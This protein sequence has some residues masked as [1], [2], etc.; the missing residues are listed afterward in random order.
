M[1][2]KIERKAPSIER[3]NS[4]FQRK[5]VKINRENIFDIRE[6]LEAEGINPVDEIGEMPTLEAEQGA[7]VNAVVSDIRK[8]RAEYAEL[9]KMMNDARFYCVLVFQ[10]E[11]QKLEFLRKAGFEK[12]TE[13]KDKNFD[14]MYL[15]GLEIAR[16]M[17]IEIETKVELPQGYRMRGKPESFGKEVIRS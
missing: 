10:S 7:Q 4:R 16:R 2:A 15:N 12:T 1:S 8:D 17:E 11:A 3:A 9:I 6:M 14:G 5:A 13:F